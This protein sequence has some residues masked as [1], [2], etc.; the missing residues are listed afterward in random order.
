[1]A[2]G[3]VSLKF[4]LVGEDKLAGTIAKAQRSMDGFGK[5]SAAS[6]KAAQKGFR[7]LS[8]TITGIPS[9]VQE[10]NQAFQLAKGVASALAGALR[11]AFDF[12]KEGE[13][14]NNVE[15]IFNQINANA[16][17]VLKSAR[18]ATLNLIDDT[19]LQ[20][21]LNKM[22]ILG[23]SVE[24][25]IGVMRVASTVAEVTGQDVVGLA[26]QISMATIS[27]RSAS[28][29]LVGV[30]LDLNKELELY[31]RRTDTTIDAM[32]EQEK[33]SARLQ[34]VTGSLAT[35][36]ATAGISTKD[37]SSRIRELET[38]LQNATSSAQQ[39]ATTLAGDL[40]GDETQAEYWEDRTE[41]LIDKASKFGSRFRKERDAARAELANTY[42]LDSKVVHAAFIEAA[43]TDR[44]AL[45]E[46]IAGRILYLK[47]QKTA[48]A[49]AKALHEQSSKDRELADIAEAERREKIAERNSKK[50]K[51]RKKRNKDEATRASI[52]AAK[53]ISDAADK[54]LERDL[55][56]EL[57]ADKLHRSLEL[58]KLKEADEILHAK[59]VMLD[60]DRESEDLMFKGKILGREHADRLEQSRLDYSD[61]IDA[62]RTRERGE[63]EDEAH[64]KKE[65]R[66]EDLE[67]LHQN[68]LRRMEESRSMMLEGAG[69]MGQ[70]SGDLG[71]F[72]DDWSIA[73]GGAADVTGAVGNNMGNMAKTAQYSIDAVGRTS[74]ALIKNDKAAAAT[75]AGFAMASGFFAV[76]A[77][78]PVAAAS[79]FTSAALFAALAGT[80]GGKKGRGKSSAGASR[81]GG[82]GGGG[83]GGRA[84]SRASNV[85]INVQGLVHGTSSDLG[86]AVGEQVNGVSGTG[87]GTAEV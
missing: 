34:I 20:Q 62:I 32:S 70:M 73:M 5:R 39:L 50:A 77:G 17:A 10:M 13:I 55:A 81:M 35:K 24:D 7:G 61:R 23:A 47:A 40:F 11:G 76:A 36:L 75:R 87:L 2:R 15:T 63:R 53:R 14:A 60:K 54:G 67:R 6:A 4:A 48:S 37:L 59:A 74:S 71:R 25:A 27:G 16:N 49:R 1:M 68:E 19:T 21:Q 26:E 86:V 42:R 41:D 56:M 12:L 29:K 69:V 18:G 31:A 66:D 22:R 33:T 8:G 43:D 85:T 64:R 3:T 52:A 44:K 9:K 57:S 58:R 51:A 84:S 65:R 79:Y 72:S 80:S 46:F 83:G 28:L 45:D 82:G 30:M 38:D 78:N